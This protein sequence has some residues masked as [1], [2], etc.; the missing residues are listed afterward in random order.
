MPL[1]AYSCLDKELV[2]IC[3]AADAHSS[4][5][6]MEEKSPDLVVF[7]LVAKPSSKAS[8]RSLSVAE[9]KACL[10]SSV[11]RPSCNSNKA[12]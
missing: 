7:T 8:R 2:M 10:V 6:F 11:L 1:H 4:I 3:K 5:S 9:D 12:C